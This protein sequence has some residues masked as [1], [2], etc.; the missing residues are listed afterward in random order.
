MY[1][2]VC[3]CACVSFCFCIHVQRCYK[4]CPDL[5]Y[6]K[7]YNHSFAH[8]TAL[9]IHDGFIPTHHPNHELVGKVQLSRLL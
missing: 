4:Y 9:S 8:G 3:V 1:M 5:R 2:S 6:F 7:F